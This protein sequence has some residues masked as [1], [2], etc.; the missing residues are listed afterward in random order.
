ASKAPEDRSWPSS[1]HGAEASPTAATS[2]QPLTSA[3][4]TVASTTSP[5]SHYPF[6]SAVHSA[7]FIIP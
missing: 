2:E 4:T 1:Q 6:I 7:P 5:A 3:L